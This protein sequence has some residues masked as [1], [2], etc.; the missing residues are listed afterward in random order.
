MQLSAKCNFWP[1]LWSCIY[2]ILTELRYFDQSTVEDFPTATIRYSKPIATAND[3]NDQVGYAEM[4]ISGEECDDIVDGVRIT[5]RIGNAIVSD[6]HKLQ[7][8]SA[9]ERKNMLF[10]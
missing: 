4:P 2:L 7:E 8:I 9:L 10:E 6:A 1:K 3:R 5:H